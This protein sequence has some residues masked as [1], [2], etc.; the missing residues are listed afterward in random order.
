MRTV[1]SLPAPLPFRHTELGV[2]N[3]PTLKI[4]INVRRPVL[5]SCTITN[6]RTEDK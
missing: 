2:I 5:H 3:D 4:R 6:T 1:S